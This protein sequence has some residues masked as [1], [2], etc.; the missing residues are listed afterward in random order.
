[1]V[2]SGGHRKTVKQVEADMAAKEASH[3]ADT[4]RPPAT[5]GVGVLAGVVAT[6][7]IDP[8]A[9]RALAIEDVATDYQE[10]KERVRAYLDLDGRRTSALRAVAEKLMDLRS[11]FKQPG[12]RGKRTDWNGESN[13]YRALANLLYTDLG[14]SG[15]VGDS[16]KRNVRHQVENVKRL[17][18]PK[19][20]WEHYGVQALTRGQRQ[21]LTAKFGKAVDQ[22]EAV[23]EE[24]A[25][26][27]TTGQTTG[28]QL[29]TLIKRI[30][31]GISVYSLASLSTMT[32]S[33]RKT[34]RE[35]LEDTRQKT[36]ALL[37][38]LDALD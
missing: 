24:T 20:D 10:A 31:A 3:R 11:H 12:S 16:T 33:Q 32:P 29:V 36:D 23:A 21:A 13:E 27:A 15:D 35:Q 30:D 2:K 4:D 34:F 38:E 1:M 22:V 6:E 17:R 8:D 7:S 19:K 5:E 14:L 26:K 37:E 18:I 28:A 25:A 9:E